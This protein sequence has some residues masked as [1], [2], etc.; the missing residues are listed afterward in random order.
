MMHTLLS[1]GK[2][3]AVLSVLGLNAC[4]TSDTGETDK[5]MVLREE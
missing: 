3:S 1:K 5:R 2:S 4:L